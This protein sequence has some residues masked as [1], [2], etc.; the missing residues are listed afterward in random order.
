M[1][2]LSAETTAPVARSAQSHV[3]LGL[4]LVRIIPFGVLAI[5]GA[6]K[7]FGAFGGGGLSA[8]EASFGQMGY[9]PPL[10][11]ALLGG[12]CEFAGGLLL[13]LG[14]L[15]P[16]AAAMVMGTM[17]N[18]FAAVADK[19]LENSALSIVLLVIAACLAFAGP[20][21]FSLDAGRPWQ[22]TGFTWG[23]ASVALAVVTAVAS[24]LAAH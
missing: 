2:T 4:L 12:T 17:I 8:T 13:M 10:F 11:F 7:L 18:A 23:G 1:S 15:T 22:R 16:L 20:G 24:L 3:D 21:R 9:H 5:F 19:P 6:Q 14:L